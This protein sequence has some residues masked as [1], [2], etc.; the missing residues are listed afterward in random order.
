M[1]NLLFNSTCEN[2]NEGGVVV[3]RDGICAAT[4]TVCWHVIVCLRLCQCHLTDAESCAAIT[5]DCVILRQCSPDT[6]K[7]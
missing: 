3:Q 7:Q 4:S 2:Q 1:T 5:S 6:L